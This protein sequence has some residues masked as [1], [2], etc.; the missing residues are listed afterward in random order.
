MFTKLEKEI[1]F[2]DIETFCREWAEGVRVEYK[3]EITPKTL[4]KIISSFA[5][6]QGGIFVIG[7]ETDE[8]IGRCNETEQQSLLMKEL[9][10]RGI[11][12]HCLLDT[13]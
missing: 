1:D 5:N 9:C 13:I 6:T 2:N 7:V 3:R 11:T 12:V 8:N 4:P 10:K